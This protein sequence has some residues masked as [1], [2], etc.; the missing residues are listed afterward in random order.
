MSPLKTLREHRHLTQEELSEQSGV[1]VRTIQR[2]ESGKAPKGYTLRV[3]AKALNVA[4]QELLDTVAPE[5][6]QEQEVPFSNT[7]SIIELDYGK[8]KIM[9]LS[10]LPFLVVPLFNILVPLLLMHVFKIKHPITKQIVSLQILW[11][12]LAPIV[13]MLFIFLKLG[14]EF[15]LVLMIVL[16]LS[17]V[18]VIVRNAVAIDRHKALYFRLNFSMI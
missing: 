14:R 12:I 2:I 6:P 8:V 7:L 4:E 17:N 1:S 3:L 11:T 9:N 13:F 16:V 10:A 15:T 5:E 18:F